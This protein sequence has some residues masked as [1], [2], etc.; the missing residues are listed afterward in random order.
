MTPKK[1]GATWGREELAATPARVWFLHSAVAT[2]MSASSSLVKLYAVITY[3][4]LHAY[5]VLSNANIWKQTAWKLTYMIWGVVE[6]AQLEKSLLH[7]SRDLDSDPWY[8]QKKLWEVPVIPAV[9]RQRQKDLGAWWPGNL[10]NRWA[11]GSRRDR[12]SQIE[13]D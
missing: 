6:I 3:A 5:Q 7:K 2:W 13:T 4:F 10:V 11:L 12:G 1:G 8:P 9:E